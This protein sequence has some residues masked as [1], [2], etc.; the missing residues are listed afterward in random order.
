V[1][2][3]GAITA[4]NI[5]PKVNPHKPKPKQSVLPLQTLGVLRMKRA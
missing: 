1:F 3:S 2:F 4:E 5:A